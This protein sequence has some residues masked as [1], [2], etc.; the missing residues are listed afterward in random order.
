MWIDTKIKVSLSLNY[1]DKRLLELAGNVVW[2]VSLRFPREKPMT[3]VQTEGTATRQNRLAVCIIGAKSACGIAI[4]ERKR[5]RGARTGM[6]HSFSHFYHLEF[7]HPNQH[8]VS[9]QFQPFKNRAIPI[10][11]FLSDWLILNMTS[12]PCWRCRET[13][14]RVIGT[15][16]GLRLPF[17][18]ITLWR[19]SHRKNLELGCKNLNPVWVEK[20][21]VSW[22]W[23]LLL[24]C[25]QMHLQA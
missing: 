24:S 15:P 13:G 16:P 18:A 20:E 17:C 1:E 25:L 2:Q 14:S 22:Q 10:E 12:S 5:L 21:G 11:T 19:W 4:T 8:L 23:C 6:N 9:S 7:V 3:R